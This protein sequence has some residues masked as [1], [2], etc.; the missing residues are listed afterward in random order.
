[1]NRTASR[2]KK[3]GSA[4]RKA[5]YRLVCQ[6]TPKELLRVETFLFKLGRELRLDDGSIHRL[7]VAVTEAVNN[8]ILHGNKQN[9]AKKV[10][11]SSAVTKH[12]L[13]IRIADEGEG[14]NPDV[15]ENPLE[16]KNLL[17][18]HGRGVF[19]MR[20]LMDEVKFKKR[21]AGQ[22]VEM[23]LRLIVR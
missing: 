6:S 9:P 10:V 19:L 7:V 2:S 22:T 13:I 21:K 4:A 1:M 20:S 17:K 5:S 14:F 16:E 23:K 8:A 11:I 12:L 15:L 18:E 3:V